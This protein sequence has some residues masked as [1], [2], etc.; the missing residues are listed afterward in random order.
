[1]KKICLGLSL[2][3]LLSGCALTKP[4]KTQATATNVAA[5]ASGENLLVDPQ[6]TLFRQNKGES[7]AWVRLTE[8]GQG[9]GLAGSTSTTAFGPVGSVRFRYKNPT[10]DFTAQP[11]VYQIVK[12]LQKDTDYELSFYYNDKKG[13]G[14]ATEVIFGVD[15]LAGKSI[16]AKTAHIKDL[17]EAPTGALDRKFRQIFVSFNSGDNTDVKVF[18]KLNIINIAKIDMESNIGSQTEVRLDE[19]ILIK[20]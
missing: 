8:K 19:A 3:I 1:M 20:E 13:K 18:A 5:M 15:N 14:S 10:D 4:A 11:G 7:K 16:V 9:V 12:G 17:K 6:F 2:A